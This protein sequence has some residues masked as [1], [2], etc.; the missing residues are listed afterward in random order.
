MLEEVAQSGSFEV[1]PVAKETSHA[2]LFV[3]TEVSIYKKKKKKKAKKDTEKTRR[4]T[5]E[6]DKP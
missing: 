5:D 2:D 1:H 4:K 3:K 6:T